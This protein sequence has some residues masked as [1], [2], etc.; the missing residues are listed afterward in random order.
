MHNHLRSTVALALL[1]LLASLS[2][3]AQRGND[4]GRASKNGNSTSTIDGVEVTIDFGRP[5]V[6]GRTIWGGLVPLGRVW[7]S[8]ADEA[9]TISFSKDVKIEGSSL[10]AGTYGLF[11]VPGEDE[12]TIV[13]NK[14][15]EQWGAFNYS[16]SEDALRVN[17][18]PKAADHEESL[19]F[20][21]EGS[22]V[23]LRWEKLAVGFKVGAA[24]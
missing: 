22:H 7:R 24:G 14:V 10:A 15:S 9:T 4:S 6:K 5:N 16:D 1:V 13:F 11:T 3:A 21:I 18:K 19:N 12:W 23:V 2:A 17:V 8:G 20:E